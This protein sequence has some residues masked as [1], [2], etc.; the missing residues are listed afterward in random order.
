M[1]RGP[2]G[3]TPPPIQWV[4]ASFL[5]KVTEDFKSTSH[6]HLVPDFRMTG[7][8]LLVLVRAFIAG[9]REILT[10]NFTYRKMWK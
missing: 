7:T 4:P 2:T 3:P 1:S 8:I 10:S 5:C 9:G 6:R